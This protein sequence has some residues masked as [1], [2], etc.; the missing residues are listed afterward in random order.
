MG[1]LRVVKIGGNVVDDPEAL[2]AFLTDFVALDGPKV[3]VHGGGKIATKTAAALGIDAQMVDGRRVTDGEMLM[4]C[5]MVYAGLINKTIVAKLQALGAN[6]IGLSGA[7]GDAM[8]AHKRTGS[9]IDY[10]FVGDI[11]H[12]NDTFLGGLIG[13]GM[14]PVLAPITHDKQGLLLNTNA[15]TIAGEA[16]RNLS[17]GFQTELIY[18]FELPG[19][20]FDIN[21]RDSVIPQLNPTQYEE[22]KEKGIIAKGMVPKLDNCFAAIAGGASRVRICQSTALSKLSDEPG[23]VLVP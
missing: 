12:V 21:D 22:L 4:V 9:D 6:A 15:D 20:L 14:V 13:Q 19:V 18:C 23:T 10:G 3:L 16:A 8:R 5:I 2:D 7:D 17:G 1:L 11:D